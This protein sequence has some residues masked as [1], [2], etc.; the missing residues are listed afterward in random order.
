M[1]AMTSKVAL[2]ARVRR[3]RARR[4]AADLATAERALARRVLARPEVVRASTVAVYLSTG[5]EPPTWELV[6]ALRARG[7]TVLSPV[8]APR[9]T[10]E[11]AAYTG[12]EG[13]RP[14]AFGILEPSAARLGVDALS[15][16]DVIVVPALAV[17]RDGRRLGRGAG[18]YDRALAHA[19]PESTRVALVFDDELVADVPAESHDEPVH[20][21][22][23]PERTWTR[24]RA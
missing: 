22:V 8:M 3:G 18:Y 12:R 17:S 1:S 6:D 23:T 14:A 4:S 10:L 5:D 11:W 21:V 13:L 15:T 19:G 7:T 2:R 20:I 16:A 24:P 9:H